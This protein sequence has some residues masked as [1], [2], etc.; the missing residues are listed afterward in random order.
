MR[1]IRPQLDSPRMAFGHQIPACLALLGASLAL[2]AC[3]G[4]DE[5]APSG[6]NIDPATASGYVQKL[7]RVRERAAAGRC[8]GADSA[9]S[10]L[11]ALKEV[12]AANAA[13]TGKDFT[14]Y[15]EGLLD[16][17]EGQISEQ[18]EQAPETISTKSTTSEPEIVDPTTTTLA[19]VE[20]APEPE[21]TEPETTTKP[22]KSEEEQ[23]EPPAEPTPPEPDGP[24]PPPPAGGGS[25][26]GGT[27]PGGITPGRKAPKNPKKAK[28]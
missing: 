21:T 23:P 28:G 22:D 6:N 7:E 26:S 19:P 15:L 27:S 9:Q 10:T 18:C 3:G 5:K 24:T 20:P 25:G 11:A 17:L 4:S 1:P 16:D 8:S 14:T 2:V 13:D 12:A